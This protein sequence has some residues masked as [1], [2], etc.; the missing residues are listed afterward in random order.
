MSRSRRVSVVGCNGSG[1]DWAAARVVLWWM[2]TRE[3]AK[4]IVTGP[5]SRQVDDIV[6]NEIR[7][8]Y[9]EAQDRLAGKMFRTSRYSI[10]EQSFALGFATNSPYNLQGFHSPN[11]LVVVTEAHAVD[12]DD[13]DAIRR[14]NPQ[15]VLMTGNPFTRAGVFYDSHHSRRELYKTVQISAFDTP[16][17]K[18]RRVV[19]PGMITRHDIADRK[20]EW[21]EESAE[22]VGG[23]LGEFPDNL[24]FV[25]VPLSAATEAARR[26]LAAEGPVV[27]ACDV[28][29]FGRDKTVVVQRQGPVARIVWKIRGQ[30]TMKIA[31]FL[32]AYCEQNP[33]DYLVVDE[34][35][36]GGGVVD[37]LRELRLGGTRLVPFTAGEKS[38]QPAYFYN[39][40]AE[41]W[42]IMRNRYISGDLD[43]D[44]DPA[45]IAQVSTRT[46]SREPEGQIRL[47]SKYKMPSSP[48]EADALAMTFAVKPAKMQIWV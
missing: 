28:A 6:W 29:R 44:D 43:T 40:T 35:G 15:R 18:A 26:G 47:Q 33:V 25:V 13:M 5:T 45:L 27:V 4:A 1:K 23:V 9:A 31:A 32:K 2:N 21:G 12:Q 24:E 3:P 42:W 8:A 17:V 46:F 7:F 39:K 41:V 30:D 19:V 37:R 20:E 38:E 34:T 16:N 14:L 48:D 36:V 11:L 22:Y 10:D